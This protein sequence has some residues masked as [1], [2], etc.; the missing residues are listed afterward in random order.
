VLM[1]FKMDCCLFVEQNTDK[2]FVFF[3]ETNDHF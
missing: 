1:V 2:A 3:S